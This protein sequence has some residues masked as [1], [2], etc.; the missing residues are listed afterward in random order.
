MDYI[1]YKYFNLTDKKFFADCHRLAK[2]RKFQP[3]EIIGVYGI[4]SLHVYIAFE[5]QLL[6][7]DVFV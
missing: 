3:R 2:S 1:S 4:S 5:N 6:G 7:A